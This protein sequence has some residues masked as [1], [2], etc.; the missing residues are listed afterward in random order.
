[1]NINSIILTLFLFSFI[2]I[3]HAENDLTDGQIAQILLTANLIDISNGE[4]AINKTTNPK[5][6][7][8]AQRMVKDHTNSN[9]E[10]ESLLQKLSIS[11][12]DNKISEVLN[13]DAE[14]ATKKLKDSNMDDFDEDY[15]KA[16]I[17]LH[18]KVIEVAETKLVPNVKN[19]DLKALLEKTH[20]ILKSHLAH[21][22]EILESID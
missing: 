1:M 7:N 18:E 17:K 6:K 19:Q 8:Y 3:A 12:K 16:E 21:A 14:K 20:P 4:F 5:V 10:V 15:I 9:K 22:L 13:E 11:L 2:S